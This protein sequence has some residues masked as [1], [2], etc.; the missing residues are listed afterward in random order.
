MN[1]MV[2]IAGVVFMA[3]LLPGCQSTEKDAVDTDVKQVDETAKEEVETTEEMDTETDEG[4][5]KDEAAPYETVN[6]TSDYFIETDTYDTGRE[7]LTMFT[8]KRDDGK[9]QNRE[10][11]LAASLMENDP[12]EQKILESYTKLTVEGQNLRVDFQE[13]G[14]LLSATSAQHSMFYDSLLGIS[15]LYGI[16]EITFV[17]PEG[18]ENITVAERKVDAPIVVADEWERSKGYY[19]LY[20]KEGKQT[21]FI[22]AGEL[23]EGAG[24]ED[25]SFQ[26]TI[27]MMQT[28][29][30]EDAFYAS[31]ITEGLEVKEVSLKDGLAIVHYTMDEEEVSASDR[32]VFEN[33]M[34]LVALDFDATELQMVNE[35]KRQNKTFPF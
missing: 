30:Q 16:E 33:A 32:I 24:G 9:D 21:W 23:D 5:T 28:A 4:K 6:V 25:L 20:D 10:E 34:Q 15:H 17:N 13:D 2:S 27:E 22:P 26:E 29:D 35:T 31:A 7:F 12:S 14:N 11:R 3:F 19:T 8:I 18:E 1:K